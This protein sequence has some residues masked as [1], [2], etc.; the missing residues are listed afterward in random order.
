[1]IEKLKI[2]GQKINNIIY[3]EQLLNIES[4]KGQFKN[5]VS[6]ILLILNPLIR[7]ERMQGY[8]E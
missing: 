1:M 3:H 5:Q 7:L 8:L 4:N 6:K 2:L